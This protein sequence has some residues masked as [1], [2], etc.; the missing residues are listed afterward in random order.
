MNDVFT[1]LETT[2]RVPSRVKPT[3]PCL[4]ASNQA[5]SLRTEKT[6]ATKKKRE[7]AGKRTREMFDLTAQFVL[8]VHP[9]RLHVPFALGGF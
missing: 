2:D 1:N 5:S 8:V 7:R 9:A 4:L 3:V 6:R